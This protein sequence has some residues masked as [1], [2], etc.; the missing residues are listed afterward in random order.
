ARLVLVAD[1][2]QRLLDDVVRA[3][4]DAA[5]GD[6]DVRA[7]QLVLD[8]G[9]QRLGV[10]GDRADP[11]GD[12]SGVPGRGRQREAVGVVDLAARQRLA[13][14]DQF[15]AGGQDD[16]A[17]A[18]PY[19]HGGAA[20]RREQPDLRRADDRAGGQRQIARPDVAAALAH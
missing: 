4:A 12:G 16:D 9:A 19:D 7:D 13:G 2:G 20:D 14:L 17:G 11:V 8:R 3:D 10:V 1:G 15:A 18:G 6:D 5:G